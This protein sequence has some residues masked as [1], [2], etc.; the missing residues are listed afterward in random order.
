M[1]ARSV[2]VAG[3]PVARTNGSTPATANA[4]PPLASLQS[5]SFPAWWTSS[6]PMGSNE[7]YVYIELLLLVMAAILFQRWFNE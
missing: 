1:R 7:G 6:S 5:A 2:L 4:S 3:A